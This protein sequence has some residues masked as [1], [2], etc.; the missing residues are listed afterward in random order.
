MV[1]AMATVIDTV[2]REG[3]TIRVYDNGMERDA[4]TGHMV[5]PPASAKITT[6]EKSNELLRRRYEL[7]RE[8]VLA[9]AAK[10]LERDGNW[11]TPNDL[12]V[13]EAL[14]E[15]VMMK[16]LNPDNAKQ[17]DAARFILQEAGLSAAQEQRDQP[18]DQPGS[19]TLILL[20]AQLHERH[21]EVIDGQVVRTDILISNNQADSSHNLDT[22]REESGA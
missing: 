3:R 16:A 13:V 20:L 11:E 1:G 2:E 14:A 12:D 18:I 7:K 4:H 15:A 9:G 17:V 22:K 5:H 6:T 8:R 19:P 21:V 10:T